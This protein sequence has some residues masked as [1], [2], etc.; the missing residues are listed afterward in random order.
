M[1]TIQYLAIAMI[2]ILMGYTI[3]R[4]RLE[5]LELSDLIVWE[6]F[7]V[8]LL[9]IA[10]EP[11]KISM[12]I[13]KIFGL[14]R[15]LDALFVLTIGLAYVLLFKLYLD[16]DK[17]EREITKLNRELAIRLKEIEDKIERKP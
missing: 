16:I 4:Y 15:G 14:G 9:I 2:F 7:L 13:K 12:E 8:I 3:F 1:Y 6:A 11:I 10:I 17:V 5:K